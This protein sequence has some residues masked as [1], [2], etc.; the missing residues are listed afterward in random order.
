MMAGIRHPATFV[1]RNVYDKVGLFNEQM[2]LSADQDFILRCY[3]GG[4]EFKVVGGILSNMSEG[5]LSTEGSER[6]RLLS[7][8]DRKMMLHNF[9]KR[10]LSY[11]WLWYSWKWRRYL[12][13]LLNM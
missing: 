2:K 9:G 13:N 5:G 4:I 6:A 3:F 1:P 8:E 7:E 10:G 12:K 11:E